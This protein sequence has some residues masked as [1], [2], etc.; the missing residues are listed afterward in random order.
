MP[1]FTAFGIHQSAP[2]LTGE[3]P[4][5]EAVAQKAVIMT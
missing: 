2:S 1:L 3:P 4:V 5:P